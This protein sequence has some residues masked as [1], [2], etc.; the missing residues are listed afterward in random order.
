MAR[1]LSAEAS[2]R[3]ESMRYKY[4]PQRRFPGFLKG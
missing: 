4:D 1:Y 3:L 2:Q